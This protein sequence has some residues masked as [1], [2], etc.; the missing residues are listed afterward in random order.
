MACESASIFNDVSI[1]HKQ[2]LKKN[3]ATAAAKRLTAK[4]DAFVCVC[5]C[6]CIKKIKRVFYL[7]IKILLLS[8]SD[9][10]V[11]HNFTCLVFK[12]EKKTKDLRHK[13]DFHFVIIA[14]VILSLDRVF[15]VLI[16]I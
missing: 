16:S 1:I 6:V 12:L 7:L 2:E 8:L 13:S 15:V 9:F 5:V 3:T 14:L 10:V 11:E 4:H